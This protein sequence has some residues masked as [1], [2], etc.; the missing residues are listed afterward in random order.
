MAS[1]ESA[2]GVSDVN[3]VSWCKISPAKAAETLRALEGGEGDEDDEEVEEGA[4]KEE[5]E[6]PRWR[7]A[8]D[9]LGS[10]GDDGIVRV[11]V[12]EEK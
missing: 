4:A 8:R 11:W 9:L 12:L 3:H 1:V 2:H 6:D 7:G 5:D 10:A